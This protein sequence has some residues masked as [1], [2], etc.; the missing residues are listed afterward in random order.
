MTSASKS[1]A[2][3][4]GALPRWT[5]MDPDLELAW[6]AHSKLTVLQWPVTWHDDVER[7]VVNWLKDDVMTKG[8]TW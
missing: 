8:G 7:R 4:A 3:L 6:L 2:K 1:F 5:K